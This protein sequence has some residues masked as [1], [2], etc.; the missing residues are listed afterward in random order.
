MHKRMGGGV[1]KSFRNT[2]EE[3]GKSTMSCSCQTYM[4]GAYSVCR[5]GA[6]F[7]AGAGPPL[8]S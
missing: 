3:K 7:G 8:K 4:R 6:G 5:A 2:K 1:H